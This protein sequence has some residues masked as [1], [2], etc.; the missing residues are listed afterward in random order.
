MQFEK[1]IFKKLNIFKQ[2]SISVNYINWKKWSILPTILG[3]EIVNIFFK[4]YLQQI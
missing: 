3:K 4:G 1:E 2:I